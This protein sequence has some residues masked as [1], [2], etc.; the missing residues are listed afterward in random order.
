MLINI[1]DEMIELH[2]IKIRK[3]KDK[4]SDLLEKMLIDK[5]TGGHILWGTD[6]YEEK[7]NSYKK[8][9][10]MERSTIL[11]R[12]LGIIKT[13]AR[14]VFEEQA[15]R[16]KKHGEVFTPLRICN[17]MIDHID[18]EWFGLEKPT[19]VT[20][21]DTVRF[22][23]DT[24]KSPAAYI[25][26][27]RLEITCGEAP[28][29]V[30]RYDPETGEM[31]P[32][33]ERKGILD[34]KLHVVS[35]VAKTKDEWEKLSERA[36]QSVYGYEFQGD[37][38]LIARIN[39]IKTFM[40]FYRNRWE[41][42]PPLSIIQK[43]ANIITWNLWQMD[44]PTG[45]IPWLKE[46]REGPSLFET[47]EEL[48][49]PYCKI[50]DWRRDNSLLYK[51]C[52]RRR[53]RN[54]KFD[55]IIGNPPYNEDFGKSGDNGNY[56]KP[57]YHLFM[58]AAYG[59]AKAVELIHPA[60]FLFNAGSTPKQWNKQMLDDEHFKVLY[61]KVKSSDVFSNTDIKGGV[62]IT[63]RD[64]TKKY[65]PIKFFL[66][67]VI[68]QN[69]KKKVIAKKDFKTISKT[70]YAPESYRFTPLMYKEHPEIK[71]M[72]YRYKDK[73]GPLI[74]KGHDYDLGSNII[75]KLDEIIFFEK[76]PND[77]QNYIRIIG[78]KNNKRC[79]RYIKRKYIANH[80]NLDKF[81]LLFS[82]SNGS[83]KFGEKI[84][85][86]IVAH[87]GYGH[88]QT[89]ISIGCLDSKQEADNEFKYVQTKFTRCMLGIL[90]VTQD[91]KKSVW[92]Y[93]PLQDFTKKSDIDWSQSVAD[94]DR[95]LY[96]KYGLSDEEISFIETHVKEMK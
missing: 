20:G 50:Y 14:K 23:A 65:D 84:A 70:V 26:S 15:G 80:E 28:Y 3:G 2:L 82:K 32:L 45:T 46:E 87:P 30:Q 27:K 61:Y 9:R 64:T 71:Q 35:A 49:P 54:M 34:R 25:D 43:T 40:E 92:M 74:S 41:S 7:G 85:L 33:A 1:Q 18:N 88:T 53:E 10:E 21:Q 58:D 79:N 77:G 31:I 76:K 39:L 59:M 60:R 66:P 24:K 73:I 16:T 69:I 81:K 4:A 96:K 91:N 94:I 48:K 56:A 47:E 95:Q 68:L 75:E 86:P 5:T 36:F 13:R 55:Y 8:G 83:G 44:G 52:N 37:S 19:E 90:K 38:L 51:D 6:E 63:Y 93:V 12:E 57:I 72:T 67:N 17:R 29:L 22:F 42:P 78:R 11:P 89:F 62:A